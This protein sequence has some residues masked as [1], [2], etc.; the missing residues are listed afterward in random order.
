MWLPG[1]H[2]A[3][4]ALGVEGPGGEAGLGPRVSRLSGVQV[5]RQWSGGHGALL[6]TM[7]NLGVSKVALIGG[8]KRDRLE[9]D[10]SRAG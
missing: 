2:G 7:Q 6:D 3:K 8:A 9:Q 5:H 4:G 1:R 10:A